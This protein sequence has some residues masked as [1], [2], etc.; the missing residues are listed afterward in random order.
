M[1]VPAGA[2][3]Y[4]GL[5]TRVVAFV[6]DA[7]IINGVAFLLVAGA[8][9]VLSVFGSSLDDLPDWLLV[10]AG[11]GG[12][13][14]L[15]GSYFVGS[16]A[17]TGQTVGMRVMAIRVVTRDGGHVSIWRGLRRLVGLV[18][19]AIPLFAGYLLILVDDRRRGLQDRIAGTLVVFVE[20]EDGEDR[21]PA[22][23]RLSLS[24]GRRGTSTLP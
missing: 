16:W 5:V 18:I 7:A 3:Q 2:P 19:A 21:P 17:L 24:P 22:A 11:A 23:D 10:A 20:A 9:L 12:W 4:A 1:D 8:S 6:I 15:A 13:V 14:L